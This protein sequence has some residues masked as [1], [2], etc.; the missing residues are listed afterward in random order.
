M[1]LF[2]YSIKPSLTPVFEIDATLTCILS[3]LNI[4]EL[5]HSIILINKKINKFIKFHPSY[6][7]NLL[8]NQFE[9][10]IFINY[11]SKFQCNYQQNN[12]LFYFKILKD[13]KSV[14][15]SQKSL[16]YFN[17]KIV[18]QSQ[19]IPILFYI[20]SQLIPIH[21]EINKKYYYYW[22]EKLN[23]FNLLHIVVR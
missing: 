15:L 8:I 22:L 2:Y 6:V 11:I 21:K 17:L 16:N 18:K 14:L 7:K 12:S 19:S 5:S 10:K 4:F 1:S 3:Y 13:L 23:K 9:S 20:M